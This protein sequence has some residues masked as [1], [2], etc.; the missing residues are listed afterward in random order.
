MPH[1]HSIYLVDEVIADKFE[2][3]Y[4]EGLDRVLKHEKLNKLATCDVQKINEYWNTTNPHQLFN[5]IRYSSKYVRPKMKSYEI[6]D[7]DITL[8]QFLPLPKSDYQKGGLKDGE[9]SN[10]IQ[11]L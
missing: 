10:S 8:C 4:T 5:T 6:Q 11:R 1:I 7:E 2:N 3:M 9:L